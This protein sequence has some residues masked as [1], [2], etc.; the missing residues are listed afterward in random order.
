MAVASISLA[1]GRD[2]VRG[3]GAHY[4]VL[5]AFLA[6]GAR[7]R[8]YLQAGGGTELRRGGK[9]GGRLGWPW[10]G[11]PAMATAERHDHGHGL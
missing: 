3:G 1:L 8:I 4:E 6:M 11:P 7:D 9:A 2:V 5:T 10:P